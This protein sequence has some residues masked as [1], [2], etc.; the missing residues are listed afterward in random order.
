[1][2]LPW[3]QPAELDAPAL[4]QP[5]GAA[6]WPELE[7]V[8]P[9]GEEEFAAAQ[10]QGG[11]VTSSSAGTCGK[12]LAARSEGAE[13]RVVLDMLD[14]F[15][16]AAA[17]VNE[18]SW[19][20][21]VQCGVVGAVVRAM[22]A[23][24]VSP[25]PSS[26]ALSRAIV[27]RSVLSTWFIVVLDPT[28]SDE[29]AEL[30]GVKAVLQAM[31]AEHPSSEYVLDVGLQVL[32]QFF[33]GR[34]AG[35]AELLA[36]QQ[37]C[38][39]QAAGVLSRRDFTNPEA[40]QGQAA[41]LLRLMCTALP[42]AVL[43]VS[44]AAALLLSTSLDPTALPKV[45]RICQGAVAALQASPLYAE[46]VRDVVVPLRLAP[47]PGEPLLYAAPCDDGEPDPAAHRRL[48]VKLKRIRVYFSSSDGFHGAST[49]PA[50]LKRKF[51]I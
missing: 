34:S 50:Q 33:R 8:A 37:E 13:P 39:G 36:R 28:R 1:M 45:R 42:G 10:A 41:R 24:S 27:E 4:V 2:A 48:R 47:P 20:D 35:A 29:L 46:R 43:G 5:G 14:A 23:F 40:L 49:R 32:F 19:L 51:A 17:C 30:G 16:C 44:G 38:V 9:V 11:L 26:P 31:R 12:I 6:A 3:T 25:P 21:M 18:A 7:L 22:S 15:V